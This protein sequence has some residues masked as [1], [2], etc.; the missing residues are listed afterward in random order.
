MDKRPDDIMEKRFNTIIEK[1]F[2]NIEKRA[3]QFK[4]RV[5]STIERKTELSEFKP[6]QPIIPRIDPMNLPYRPK[7]VIPKEK[8]E[9]LFNIINQMDTQQLKQYSVVNSINLNVEESNTGDNL[10]HKII[11]S[12]NLLK[13]EFHRLNAIKFLVQNNVHPDKPNR[14]NQTPLH[15]ACKAQMSTIVEY[16]VSLQV[17]LNYI[18]NYGYSPLHYALQGKI[19]LYEEPKEIKSFI[20]GPKKIDF[21]KKDDLL[22][23]KKDLWEI[24][25]EDPFLGL[26]KNTIET[27]I[28]SDSTIE[29]MALDLNKKISD[30][31]LDEKVGDRLKFYKE[32]LE[33]VRN[34]INNIVKK[35]WNN[36]PNLTELEIH[37]KQENSWVSKDSDK[38]SPLKVKDVKKELKKLVKSSKEEIK[39]LCQDIKEIDYSVDEKYQENFVKFYVD[40]YT[41][42]K[43]SFQSTIV[44]IG[45]VAD[46]KKQKRLHLNKNL[47]DTNWNNFNKDKMDPKALDFADN[48]INW[49]DLSFIGGSRNIQIKYIN[50]DNL[51]RIIN[52]DTIEEKVFYILLDNLGY[53]AAGNMK[54]LTVPPPALGAINLDPLTVTDG[55]NRFIDYGRAVENVDNW[56]Q[57]DKII[58][59]WNQIFSNKPAIP[60]PVSPDPLA[61]GVLQSWD[62]NPTRKAFIDKWTKL[63]ST[64]NKASVLYSMYSAYA[65]LSSPDNLNGTINSTLS[66]LCSALHLCEDKII[67]NNILSNGLKKFVIS[68]IFNQINGPVGELPAQNPINPIT[69]EQAIKATIQILLSPDLTGRNFDDYINNVLNPDNQDLLDRINLPAPAPVGQDTAINDINKENEI[70]LIIEEITKKINL[71]DDKPLDTDI[72]GI[73][74]FLNNGYQDE[75]I[76]Y[77]RINRLY[78]VNAPLGDLQSRL[79]PDFQN[80]DNYSNEN[81]LNKIIHILKKRQV[82][83]L[84]PYINHIFE[85]LKEEFRT[86]LPNQSDNNDFSN[87]KFQEARCLGLY[88]LGLV[89]H[90]NNP[91]NDN[92][93]KNYLVKLLTDDGDEKEI[94]ILSVDGFIGNPPSYTFNANKIDDE[95]IPLL[96]NF[97]DTIGGN[98]LT[99]LEKLNYYEDV[100]VHQRR[101][102]LKFAVNILKERNKNYLINI[103]HYVLYGSPISLFN[104]MDNN[105]NLYKSF[106][107]IY[108]I[109]SIVIDLLKFY[110]YENES[111]VENIIQQLNKYNGYIFLYYY[112]FKQNKLM[113]LPQFNYYEIP[114]LNKQGKF[115]YFDDPNSK[116]YDPSTNELNQPIDV[117]DDTVLT[118]ISFTNNIKKSTIYNQGLSSFKKLIKNIQQKIMKGNYIIKKNEL[119]LRKELKIP[120]SLSSMLDELYKFNLMKIIINVFENVRPLP[121]D[122][123]EADDVGDQDVVEAL[124][125]GLGGSSSGG[126]SSGGSSSGSSNSVDSGSRG[127][128]NIDNIKS[129]VKKLL[130]NYDILEDDV[131]IYM[132][133]GKLTQEIMQEQSKM[134]IQSQTALI[135]NE[136]IKAN[137]AVIK[138]KFEEFSGELIVNPGEYEVK[139]NIS[140][141]GDLF[142]YKRDRPINY[143]QFSGLDL[144]EKNKTCSGK[145]DIYE[146]IIYPEEYAI[147]ELLKSKYVLKTHNK[148]YLKLL[149]NDINPYI[150][151]S[152]NQSAIFPVL[153]FHEDEIIKKLK[154]RIDYREF[155]DINIFDFLKDEFNIHLFKLTNDQ[156]N[157]KEWLC[158]FVLYQKEEVMNLILS[159]DKF[160]NNVPKHLDDSFMVVCYIMNQ[161]ISESI[162]KIEDSYILKSIRTSYLYKDI[163]KYLFINEIISNLNIYEND[164]DNFI[165]D[166]INNTKKEKLILEKNKEKLVEGSTKRSIEN[167]LDKKDHEIQ[168]LES[169]KN[170]TLIQRKEINSSPILDRY[171]LLVEN[172]N[173][174]T[175]CKLLSKLVCYD[176]LNKSLDLFTF[177][178]NTYEKI[179]INEIIKDNSDRDLLFNVFKAITE[180]Y[181]HTNNIGE[182]YFTFGKYTDKNNVL[183]FA[184]ELLIFMCKHFIIYP[185]IMAIKK[186]L[187]EYYKNKSPFMDP[188]DINRRIEFCFTYEILLGDKL[189]NL[190]DVL[191]D[192]ISVKIVENATNIF[193][194]SNRENEFNL[195]S[196]KELFDSVTT[197]LTLNPIRPIEENETVFKNIKEINSYF[198]TFVNR[199]V[200]NWNVIIEN[201]LKFNINQG[202]IIRSL[203]NLL[204]NPE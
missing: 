113:K 79:P 127:N 52:Y 182:I 23:I 64:N 61:M 169:I 93:N 192:E 106:T 149:D 60:F 204:I 141:L 131:Q 126:S 165:S 20:S 136:I 66:G 142:D 16:L 133:I 18:D 45:P 137:G 104:L 179:V 120:P 135:I 200:L 160:G 162:H 91:K 107:E 53:D 43:S 56:I 75:D 138:S 105:Q 99:T 199:T 14:E 84:I 124:G 15:L 81:N 170:G 109:I 123:V 190:K 83:T 1:R 7:L 21:D 40:F 114:S 176:D 37:E 148:L 70:N 178:V 108:P 89:P 47:N 181:S 34:S 22:N 72:I 161:Y 5:E 63:F 117:A 156:L 4:E 202:R 146:F 59:A 80:I 121:R 24:L 132:I 67:T 166:L 49:D 8:T 152:N 54:N 98:I 177:K 140:N 194:N 171:S 134:Y 139:L 101:P 42:N 69:K 51:S 19:E 167:E 88:Y 100:F 94:I 110:G 78:D 26:L 38:L 28:F 96:G 112:I 203:Y 73:T 195:Q 185:Y 119:I 90:F 118:D 183:K 13:K 31:G 193:E 12:S 76:E 103:L 55:V 180:F 174:G 164:E 173:I 65:C 3:E 97:V 68:W 191:L 168:S 196:V 6:K 71:M 172:D 86:V 41:A 29:K 154:E 155:S 129:K 57:Y 143:F 87:I 175:L 187:Y 82:T 201:V 102:P 85:I 153:K 163:N 62:L 184:K 9:E 74:T 144:L 116:L 46:K 27:S 50:K 33:T 36:F 145:D 44:N 197:L 125:P 92:D 2:M 147:S 130:K 115:L 122:N 95:L 10:I 25:K 11:T 30:K 48:I 39:K 189:K 159:N 77:F 186:I 128:P 111:I 158:N 17:D 198:D 157:F 150:L 58:L 32:E 188:T 35:K 151:D